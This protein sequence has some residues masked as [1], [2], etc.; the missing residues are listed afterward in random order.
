M[1]FSCDY[2]VII[3]EVLSLQQTVKTPIYGKCR[4]LPFNNVREPNQAP[5]IKEPI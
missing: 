3:Q 5:D 4:E 1:D 2:T